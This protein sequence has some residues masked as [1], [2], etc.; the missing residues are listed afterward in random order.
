LLLEASGLCS[1]AWVFG[2]WNKLAVDYQ[3]DDVFLEGAERHTSEPV[4]ARDKDVDVAMTV[5]KYCYL[6][7]L[8][9][10]SVAIVISLVFTEQ[11]KLA[12]R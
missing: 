9:I 7:G 3:P 1:G 11:T 6:M 12:E 2:R 4:T 10:F 8:L 5:I